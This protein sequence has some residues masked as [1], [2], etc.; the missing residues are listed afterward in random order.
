MYDGERPKQHRLSQT[1]RLSS[2]FCEV[3]R[4][5]SIILLFSY[6]CGEVVELKSL[7]RY[8]KARGARLCSDI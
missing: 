4:Y 8:H 2:K 7:V 1:R 3:S 5:L 6:I